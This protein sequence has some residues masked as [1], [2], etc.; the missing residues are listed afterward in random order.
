MQ[1]AYGKL[2]EIENLLRLNIVTKMEEEYGIY[3]Q[4]IASG[5]V[6]NRC[7]RKSFK[8]LHF[9]EL[10]TYCKIFPLLTEALSPEI[11]LQL[12]SLN[13][14]RNKIAHNRLLSEYEFEQLNFVYSCFKSFLEIKTVYSK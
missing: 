13:S 12:F 14:I 2:Y 7:T 11:I 6:C 1:D 3:W 4:R 5:K 8:D 10:V 9:H